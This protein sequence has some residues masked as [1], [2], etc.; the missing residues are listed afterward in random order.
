MGG[1]TT[2]LLRQ[3]EEAV[4]ATPGTPVRPSLLDDLVQHL[5]A[6]LDDPTSA[7][8]EWLDEEIAKCG[9]PPSKCLHLAIPKPGSRDPERQ[10]MVAP[11]SLLLAAG[12]QSQR[13]LRT[14][15][16]VFTCQMNELAEH[17]ETHD[18]RAM[19]VGTVEEWRRSFEWLDKQERKPVRIELNGSKLTVA[20]T[21]FR[22]SSL[23]RQVVQLLL[24]QRSKTVSFDSFKNAGLARKSVYD[25][26]YP[27]RSKLSKSL[28]RGTPPL[29]AP[30]PSAGYRLN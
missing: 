25:T 12:R 16:S 28:P 20:G 14:L 2:S 11:S 5:E 7:L 27:L 23:E 24:Q 18:H 26:L 29:I 8:R 3:L 21:Q 17:L 13:A 15:A 6:L 4:C 10:K 22:L 1:T 30:V 9:R 19:G